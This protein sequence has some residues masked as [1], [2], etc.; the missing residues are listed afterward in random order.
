M[1]ESEAQRAEPSPGPK[2]VG[3]VYFHGMGSQRHYE[4][5]CML[6][7]RLDH[8]AWELG[9]GGGPPFGGIRLHDRSAEVELPRGTRVPQPGHDVVYVRVAADD[10]RRSLPTRN[11]RFFEAYWAPDTANG[12]TALSVVLWLVRQLRKPVWLLI[13]RWREFRRL[14]RAALVRLFQQRRDRGREDVAALRVRTARLLELYEAFQSAGNRDRYPQGSFGQ[15]LD[16]VRREQHSAPADAGA[17]ARLAREWRRHHL[18]REAAHLLGILAALLG[19]ALAAGF[20]LLLAWWL[21]LAGQFAWAHLSGRRAFPWHEVA[22][23]RVASAFPIL[24]SVLG[25]NQFLTDF[26]GDVQQ[27][28]SYE[29]TDKLYARRK[30]VLTD[31]TAQL[32]QV[33]DDPDCE[34]VVIVAHSLGSAVAV[35]TLL[36]LARSNRASGAR[37]PLEGPIPLEKIEHLV[38]YGSPV[39]KINYFFYV[40]QSSSGTYEELAEGLR[41]DIGTP[42]F[43]TAD[44]RPHVHWINFW[45]KG[46][47]IS[48]PT[49]TVGSSRLTNQEVDNVRVANYVLPDLAGSHGAY[50]DRRDVLRVLLEVILLRAHSYAAPG[51]ATPAGAPAPT[52]RLGPGAA[53]WLQTLVFWA[54]VVLLPVWI[55]LAAWERW[56]RPPT[57][58][59]FLGLAVLA[60]FAHAAGFVAHKLM[61]RSRRI[62]VDRVAGAAR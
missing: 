3:V 16:F 50:P 49:E 22:W 4:E 52:T 30:K 58:H 40:A 29:E 11:L 36:E 24:L 37:D 34:R 47:L 54:C 23:S 20:L 27:Y 19:G 18:L 21:V 60:L 42:P 28:T 8:A 7:D 9:R 57:H 31:A 62:E 6:V 15:F 1:P 51:S 32:L 14:R 43:S 35:D 26:V 55:L 56:L 61:R 13:G 10:P 44:H 46:D 48:G 53:S 38:T 45:D 25:V 33:L 59:V 39:D 2:Y 12:T 17:L 41:G 5:M